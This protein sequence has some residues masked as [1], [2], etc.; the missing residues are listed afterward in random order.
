M[1]TKCSVYSFAG[2]QRGE[3]PQQVPG[4][5]IMNGCSKCVDTGK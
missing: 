2:V 4:T 5:G 1:C 3:R